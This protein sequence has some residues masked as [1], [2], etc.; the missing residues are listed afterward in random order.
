MSYEYILR[1]NPKDIVWRLYLRIRSSDNV[2][3]PVL[4]V[5][6]KYNT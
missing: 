5:L 6:N 2:K 3:G 4:K 1:V